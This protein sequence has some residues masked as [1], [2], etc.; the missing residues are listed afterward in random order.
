MV[1]PMEI[2]ILVVGWR[3]WEYGGS[4]FDRF[5]SLHGLFSSSAFDGCCVV[6]FHL[7]HYHGQG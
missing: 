4:E 5:F 7:C 6:F 3:E 2:E 1:L